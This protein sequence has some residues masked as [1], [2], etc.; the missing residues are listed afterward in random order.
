MHGAVACT[1]SVQSFSFFFIDLN[2]YLAFND[3]EWLWA[4]MNKSLKGLHPSVSQGLKS[5]NAL[6]ATLR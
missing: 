4:V 2:P 6:T 1:I 3:F 5:E